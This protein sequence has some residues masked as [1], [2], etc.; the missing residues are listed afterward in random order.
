MNLDDI[1]IKILDILQSKANITNANLASEVGISAS[2]MIE[3]VKRLENANVI[4]KYVALVDSEKVGKGTLALVSIY[5]AAHSKNAFEK[6]TREIIEIS[7]VLECY[8]TSGEEDFVLKVVVKNISDF[9]YF[10]LNKLTKIS[11]VNK[12]KTNFILSTVKFDTKIHIE[13]GS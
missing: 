8:H 2:G 6:F 11:G 13:K 1:D 7:E 9:E 5:L 3:R 4:R 10:I 12:V